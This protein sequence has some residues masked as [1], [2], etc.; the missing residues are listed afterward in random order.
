[1]ARLLEGAR[2]S[3]GTSTAPSAKA[4]TSGCTSRHRSNNAQHRTPPPG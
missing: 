4:A 1:V 2:G 3:S